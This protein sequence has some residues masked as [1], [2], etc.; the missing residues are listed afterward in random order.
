ME[1]P[2]GAASVVAIY[3]VALPQVFGYLLPRCGRVAI[4]EDLTADTFRAVAA[5]SSPDPPRVTVAWLIGVSRH[6]LVDHW[7]RVRREQRTL[8]AIDEAGFDDPW[9]AKLDSVD[10]HAALAQL[11]P[12]QRAALS[13]RY[14]DGLPV[15]R[16]AEYLGLSNCSSPSSPRR[17]WTT[18]EDDV[19]PHR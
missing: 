4:A 17:D 15:A 6:K 13:P 2:L 16:V 14:L 10:A 18:A 19:Q 11:P 8:A 9:D 1:P 12:T 5:A 7:R 3:P